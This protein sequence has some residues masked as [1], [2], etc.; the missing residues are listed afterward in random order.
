MTLDEMK[1]KVRVGIF[2]ACVEGGF[3]CIDP[4]GC[5]CEKETALIHDALDELAEYRKQN[6][7]QGK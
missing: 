4:R 1:E 5:D 7:V 3:D 6:E 2:W